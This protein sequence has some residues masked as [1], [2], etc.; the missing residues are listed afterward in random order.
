MGIIADRTNTKW[1]K[2]RPYLLWMML[3]MAVTGVLAFTT[4]DLGLQGK[5][6]YAF[7]T[8]ILVM[9][10]YTAINIPYSALLGVLSPHSRE[11]TSASTYRFVLAF[12]G[13]FIIQG[14]TLPL[15]NSLGHQ[16]QGVSLSGGIVTIE[17]VDTRTSKIIVE[18]G[19]GQNKTSREFLV[20]INREGEGPPV[21]HNPAGE[22]VLEQGFAARR[23]ALGD[24]FSSPFGDRLLYEASSSETGVVEMAVESE[25][26]LILRETGPGISRITLTAS[27]EHH[28]SRDHSFTV[29]INE[30]GNGP[31]VLAEEIPDVTHDPESGTAYSRPLG[32]LYRPG[33]GPAQL[34]RVIRGQRGGFGRYRAATGR[35]LISERPASRKSP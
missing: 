25:S 19:D 16:D 4:P 8:Y 3:P 17:E 18:A 23:I 14:A 28:G 35:S 13:A 5:I 10:A 26:V 24:I 32:I 34:Q 7:I 20:K 27:D 6:I 15:V 30:A 21:V 11:R 2:F 9:M 31:P 12:A 1:G 22:I 29:R 33:R